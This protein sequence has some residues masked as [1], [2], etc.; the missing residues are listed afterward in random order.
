MIEWA[1]IAGEND[2]FEEAHS[3][4]HLLKGLLCMVNIIP[5]NPTTGYAGQPADRERIKAFRGILLNEY[6]VQSTVRVRR[7]ID[8]DAGCG[9]LK[10][11]VAGDQSAQ[12]SDL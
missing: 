7:G 11:A 12:D 4:G 3:L 10:A 2:S 5:L 9:Q 8:I 1:M 6:G